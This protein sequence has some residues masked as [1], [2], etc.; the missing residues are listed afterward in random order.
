MKRLA[1]L[2][3][4]A[5]STWTSAQV[6]TVNAKIVYQSIDGFGAASAF[7][8]L[9]PP[10]VIETEY[11]SSGIGLK[12]IRVNLVPDYAD[13]IASY[14]IGNCVSVHS[15]ATILTADLAN[16][17]T[18]VANGA[19]LWA[20]EWSPPGSMKSNGSYSSGGS[21][22]GNPT[23]YTALAAAQASFVA[24]MS[25]SYGI[26]VYAISPQ[27]EPNVSTKYP[28]CTWTSQQFT[29]YVPYLHNALVAAGYPNTKIMIAEPGHWNY[30]YMVRA[31]TKPAVAPLV[32][33]VAAHAYVGGNPPNTPTFLPTEHNY[34]LSSAQHIW[35]TEV[36][37]FH[38]KYDGTMKSGLTYALAIHNWLTIAH[39]NAWHYW[40]I[41]GQHYTDNQG[42]TSQT[43]ELAKRAFVIG[44][45]ARFATGMSEIAATAN[46][47]PGIYVTAFL[48]L[49]TRASVIVAINTSSDPLSQ[50]FT[51]S[52]RPG[53]TAYSVTP[54]ITDQNNSI[55][56]QSPLAVSNSSFIAT[57]PGSSVTSFVT[58]ATV[59]GQF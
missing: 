57:L 11:S 9:V 18:A 42:L 46:P 2:L 51:I 49:S 32:G 55:A 35:Q 53:P 8:G 59:A 27:N 13:C 7:A 24:L 38:T 25:G 28:S 40:E 41:S 31:M 16:T 29:D 36:S 37:D 56:E 17:Q 50:T 21:F 26:P 52:G 33:I 43:N 5:S 44:N 12:Y 15:G 22:I 6:A 58:P 39:V 45:W 54:Y 34:A 14:G 10:S 47:Q 23:N 1:A 48:N 3:I 19:V 4:L 30:G 20:T